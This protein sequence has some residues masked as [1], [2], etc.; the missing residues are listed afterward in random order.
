MKT[1]KKKGQKTYI[2]E[3]LN[4]DL[5]R[6]TVP[7][8]W[9][10]TFGPV[11][12]YSGKGGSS[13]GRVCLRFY[14]G[15]KENLRAVFTDVRAFR[16][17]SMEIRERRTEVKR[18]VVQRRDGGGMKNVEVEARVTEWVNPDDVTDGDGKA[19]PYLAEL[20]V[21]TEDTAEPG[22]IFSR[23]QNSPIR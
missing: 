1:E 16:D 6:I 20:A 22:S 21:S 17:E 2:L 19:A 13:D 15:S 4:G 5:R 7:E 18:Q 14:E 12:P 10:L 8:T 3:L 11:V 9:K 23:I